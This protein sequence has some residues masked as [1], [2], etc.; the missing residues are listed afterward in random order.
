M[1]ETKTSERMFGLNLRAYL[2]E[3]LF[4][5]IAESNPESFLGISS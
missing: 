4:K 1:V 2:G 5:D 3:D